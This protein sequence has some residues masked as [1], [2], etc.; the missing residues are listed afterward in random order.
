MI[1]SVVAANLSGPITIAK[2][3]QRPAVETYLG[4]IAL[5]SISLA[6]LNLLPVPMLMVVISLTPLRR[7]G[8]R[9]PSGQYLDIKVGLVFSGLMLLLHNDLLRL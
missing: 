3:E 5:I 6:V 8:V 9:F 1:Q 4:F 7:M 2:I